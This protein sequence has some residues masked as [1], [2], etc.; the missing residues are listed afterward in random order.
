MTPPVPPEALAQM[1]DRQ[2]IEDV[3][4][5]YSRA[6]DRADIELLRSRYH[7]EAVEDHGET[8]D[9]LTLARTVDRFE[10]RSGR[11]AISARRL[12]W[13]WNQE[14]PM[15]ET[16]GRGLITPDPGGLVRG[17]KRPD[18]ILYRD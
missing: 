11:W 13:E 14:L 18:D 10:K 5:R 7:G 4:V 12:C 15:R 16:W 2:Q 3:L 8:F 17:A 6:V 9:T 1:L